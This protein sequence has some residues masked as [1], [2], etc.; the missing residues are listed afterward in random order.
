MPDLPHID[1]DQLASGLRRAGMNHGFR[2]FATTHLGRFSNDVWRLDLDNGTRLIVKYPFREPRP[3]EIEDLEAHFYRELAD[4]H[5]ALPVPRFVG[6]LDG[7]L[8]IEYHSLQP[9]SF[10]T[11]VSDDHA[12]LAIDALADVHGTF[13]QNPPEAGWLPTFANERRRISIQSDYDSAW[14]RNRDRLVDYAPEF[15]ELGDALVGRLAQTTKPMTETATLL[16]GD[17]H[18][19]NLPMTDAGVLL[20]DWQDVQTGTAGFDLAVFTTM[21]FTETARPEKE[22]SLIE[23]HANR[24][25][26]RGLEWQDPWR[27]YRLGLLRRAARIVEIADSNFASLPW[28][29]RR[30]AIA[31]VAH[32]VGELIR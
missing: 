2:S 17:A 10:K 29:F 31:A 16:H 15:A 12:A 7:V 28:V 27:D 4:A 24:I 5:K 9:F 18:A 26:A 22:R 21:S 32:E 19:E 3:G 6:Y 8:V 20:L 1:L 30:S 14:Q 11:G 13:W 23:R 25:H